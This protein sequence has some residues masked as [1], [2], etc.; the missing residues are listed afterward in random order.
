MLEAATLL[1]NIEARTV[2][3]TRI[4]VT[5]TEQCE[6]STVFIPMNLSPLSDDDSNP[7][8]FE[9]LVSGGPLDDRMRRYATWEE[10]D[11]GHFATCELV[12]QAIAGHIPSEEEL[13][14][15]EYVRRSWHERVLDDD[16]LDEG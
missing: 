13:T 11:V 14:E 1:G 7:I 4:Q 8:C 9:T 2:A 6:V 15:R 3:R 5:E 10:A 16:D 12:R